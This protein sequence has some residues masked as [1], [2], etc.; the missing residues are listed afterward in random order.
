M[1]GTLLND[2][3]LS[4]EYLAE[5]GVLMETWYGY[6]DYAR[7][8]TVTPTLTTAL[9]THP[10]RAILCD[11]TKLKTLRPDV[12]EYLLHDKVKQLAKAGLS[13]YALVL[14][15]EQYQA[16]ALEAP[17]LLHRTINQGTRMGLNL[18]VFDDVRH[19]G[20]W[21]KHQLNPLAA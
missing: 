7:F 5:P 9:A 20:A 14:T 15:P 4:L 19:A 11:L 12:Q 3:Y 2:D 13:N 6:I 8:V 17:S 10:A 16:L 18:Q 21:L 1:N